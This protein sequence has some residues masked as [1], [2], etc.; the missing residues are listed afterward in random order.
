MSD[1]LHVLNSLID[2]NGSILIPNLMDDVVPVTEDEKVTYSK[3]DFNVCEYKEEIG[4][5]QLLHNENKVRLILN[6]N[7]ID[8]DIFSS[9]Y[10]IKINI[11]MAI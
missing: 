11:L 6:N 8:I 9:M 5:N 1:L 4:T 3:I 7:F 10:A 2:S